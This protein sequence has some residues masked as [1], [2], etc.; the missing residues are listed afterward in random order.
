LSSTN[1][2]PDS[3]EVKAEKTYTYSP[4][5]L[6]YQP[7]MKLDFD[8]NGDLLIY[9]CSAKGRRYKM[10]QHI[11]KVVIPPLFYI[12]TSNFYGLYASGWSMWAFLKG[13]CS[14]NATFFM[15]FI[16]KA[17]SSNATEKLCDKLYLCSDGKHIRV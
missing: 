5:N 6:P 10:Y 4:D 16:N 13:I 7:Q 1:K 11:P 2:I 14:L 17:L 9:H 15:F 3:E 12:A 8:K